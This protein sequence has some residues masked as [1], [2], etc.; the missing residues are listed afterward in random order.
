MRRRDKT[1]AERSEAEERELNPTDGGGAQVPQ[2][3]PGTGLKST[4]LSGRACRSGGEGGG[5]QGGR[6]RGEEEEMM[7]G[8][9]KRGAE[10]GSKVTGGSRIKARGCRGGIRWD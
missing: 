2:Q 3:A 1:K 4:H 5:L 6:E 10:G 7:V 9:A 8:G